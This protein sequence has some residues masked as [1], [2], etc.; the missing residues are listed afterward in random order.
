V[1]DGIRVVII[2]GVACGPKAASRLKRLVPNADVTMIE[3]DCLVSYG[4]CGLP[5][6]VGDVFP[7]VVVLY[8]KE[9]K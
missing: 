7:D 4:A 3:R 1:K 8:S 5:H 6:Y 9:R 2:G